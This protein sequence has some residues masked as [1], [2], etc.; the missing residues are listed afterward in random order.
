[1]ENKVYWITGLA[2]SGKT[3]LAKS[4]FSTLKEQGKCAVLLDGD[5][6]REVFGSEKEYTR[7]ARLELAWR[8]AK[9]CK[10]LSDQGINAVCATISLF[11][12]VQEW[13]RNNIKGY[14]E[15]Y[16]DVPM[17]VLEQR[18]QKGLY[19]QAKAGLVRDV[20]GVDIE[21]EFPK[22]PDFIGRVDMNTRATV[23]KI[24]NL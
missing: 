9:L 22:S 16:L 20:V 7:S 11:H 6:L 13:N 17:A 24:L 18:D 8:N 1:M 4:L 23:E 19:S 3:T 10:F 14:C 5:V 21:P 12:D 2:G 15:I